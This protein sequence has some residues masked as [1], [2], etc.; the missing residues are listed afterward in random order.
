M[1]MIISPQRTSYSE[2]TNEGILSLLPKNAL[3]GYTIAIEDNGT[4]FPG[5]V[6][7]SQFFTGTNHASIDIKSEFKKVTL[8]QG[9]DYPVAAIIK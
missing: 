6:G 2:G 7:L 1:W 8:M 3:Q 5:I 9:Y 4:N